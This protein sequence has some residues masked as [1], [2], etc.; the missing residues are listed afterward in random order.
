MDIPSSRL[1]PLLCIVYALFAMA[2][3]YIAALGYHSKPEPLPLIDE[4]G[5]KLK[6]L[7]QARCIMEQAQKH[8]TGH[9]ILDM[10]YKGWL[11]EY[12]YKSLVKYKQPMYDGDSFE[13]RLKSYNVTARHISHIYQDAVTALTFLSTGSLVLI[14]FMLFR[15]CYFSSV[16]LAGFPVLVV[17]VCVVFDINYD[18]L[19]YCWIPFI[20][21][22]GVIFFSQLIFSFRFGRPDHR[23]VEGLPHLILYRRGL[24]ILDLGL[25]LL[26]GAMLMEGGVNFGPGYSRKVRLGLALFGEE[27]IVV[28]G[29]IVGII[30]VISGLYYLRKKTSDKGLQ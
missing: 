2:G 10:F 30:L 6:Q 4:T 16:L 21:F 24:L 22:G 1:T 12:D 13:K 7:E 15:P 28:I 11:L 18:S 20:V 3:I 17:F 19:E 8:Q 14:L 25:F 26:L 9:V 5:D 29:F 27:G 23:T